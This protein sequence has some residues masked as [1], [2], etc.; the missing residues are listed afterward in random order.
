MIS[1]G[2]ATHP[3]L[4]KGVD[5][6]G[7]YL[8]RALLDRTD[9]SYQ[10][11]FLFPTVFHEDPRYYAMERGNVFKR[12]A[13]AATRVIITRTDHGHETFNIAGIAGKF[14]SDAISRTYYPNAT[15][16]AGGMAHR[17]GIACGRDASFSIVREFYPDI[18]ARFHHHP[19]PDA[20]N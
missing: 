13:Y 14:G 7:N 6:Y 20:V 9:R 10:S 2:R 8:W 15:F 18:A 16:N 17:F 11:T 5:G 3:P 12:A 19:R 1:E 4:G